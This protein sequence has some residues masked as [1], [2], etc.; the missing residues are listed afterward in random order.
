MCQFFSSQFA[1]LKLAI[2]WF[3]SQGVGLEIWIA[4][5][6][7]IQAKELKFYGRNSWLEKFRM[8]EVMAVSS[9]FVMMKYTTYDTNDL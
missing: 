6:K 1:S 7:S 9:Y 3:T 2:F 8:L 4:S 5:P